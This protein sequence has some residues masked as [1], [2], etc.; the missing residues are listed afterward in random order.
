MNEEDY[1]LW[2]EIRPDK[3]VSY[4]QRVK[5]AELLTK[6][7]NYKYRVPCACPA[8]IKEIINKLD[9]LNDNRESNSSSNES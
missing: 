5:M 8:S 6:Y 7:L 9:K 1:K 4:Y 2:L 3:T